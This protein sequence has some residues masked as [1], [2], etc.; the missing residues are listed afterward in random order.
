M[1]EEYVYV[2][3][4]FSGSQMLLAVLGAAAAGVAIGYLTAPKAGA[5]TRAGIKGMARDT[6]DSARQIPVALKA[7]GS[8]AG[9]VFVETMRDGASA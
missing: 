9:A 2:T 7:A 5:E 8:A 3:K 4:G 6:V 1:N